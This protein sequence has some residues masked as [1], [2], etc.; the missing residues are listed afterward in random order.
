LTS[1]AR[2][3]LQ[4]AATLG[5]RTAELHMT[6]ASGMTDAFAPEP[7]DRPA[8][9]TMAE[10]MIE[11][12]NASLDLLRRSLERL[13]ES[14]Q[15]DEGA[16]E[17]AR[18]V[19]E[20][21]DALRSRFDELRALDSA[22]PRIRVHGDYHLGQV[23]RTEDDVV[24]LDFEGEPDRPIKERRAKQSPVKD[25][26]G[27]V[28][29]FGYAAYAALLAFTL[30]APDTYDRL[31]PWAGAWQQAAS[32]AFTSGYLAAIAEGGTATR[33]LPDGL[34]D[35]AAPPR[36][37]T[38]LLRAFVLDKAMYELAYELNNRPDWVRIPLIAIRQLVE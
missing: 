13:R 15:F 21:T 12:A 38:T 11:H 18:R 26:A 20:A 1:I 7:L 16:Q 24:I 35:P 37:W 10:A 27:M 14:G 2:D 34:P 30:H 9:A 33:L 3:A 19:L 23:L 31:E 22:G 32:E 4:N 17:H 5:K 8:I 36:W 28:R 6:L 29:S 25:V